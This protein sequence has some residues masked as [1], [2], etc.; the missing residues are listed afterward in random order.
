MLPKLEDVFLRSKKARLV[1]LFDLTQFAVCILIIG[2]HIFILTTARLESIEYGI[3][4]YFLKHRPPLAAHPDIVLVEIDQETIDAIGDWPWPLRYHSEIIKTLSDWGAKAVVL[5]F[6]LPESSLPEEK[7]VFLE[8][9][10]N[11]KLLYLPLTLEYKA[12]KKFFIHSMP[13]VLEAENEKKVWSR[14]DPEIEEISRGVGHNNLFSDTDGV[15]R[16]AP[17]FLA[18]EGQTVPYLPLQVAYEAQGEKAPQLLDLGLSMPLDSRRQLMVNWIGRHYEDFKHYSYS[19][20]IRSAQ[21]LSKGRDAVIRPEEIRGKICWIG[22]SAPGVADFKITPLESSYPAFAVHANVLNNLLTK[23]FMRPASKSVNAFALAM[24]GFAAALL[25]VIFRSGPSFV[26]GLLM[27]AGWVI[28]SYILFLREGIWVYA[29][30]PLFLILTLFIFSA[31]YSQIANKK[32]QSRLFHLATRDGLTGL[33]VIRH[34]REI[35]NREVDQAQIK[36]EPL[37]LILIDIDNFKPIND[38]FGHPAGDMVLKKTAQIICGQFRTRR[39]MHQIDFA[40]RY[41]GEEFI[42][43]VRRAPLKETSLK[44]AERI[45][46]AV[47]KGIFEWDGKPIKV[48]ISLGVSSLHPGENVPDLMVRRADEALYRAKR[49]GKNQVCI[50]TFATG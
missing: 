44:V 20:V 31:I 19:T 41:G 10:K 49:A 5:D 2:F 23:N 32:E 24:I 42:V 38:T 40:A 11:S 15:V 34:F 12:A 7:A 8:T 33:F 47:E 13:V 28:F 48:T 6:V 45:R 27:G 29:F 43:L 22:L 18:Y 39:P 9:I 30:Q 35:L 25:F 36:K 21:A 1:N 50:E 4:S 46:S 17:M 37:S 26:A 14:S 3:L 16:R